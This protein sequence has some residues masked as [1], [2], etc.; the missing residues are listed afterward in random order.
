MIL[1][2][3][4]ASQVLTLVAS[5]LRYWPFGFVR[6]NF[7]MIPLLIFLAGVG[8]VT[9]WQIALRSLRTTSADGGRQPLHVLV[10]AGLCL[11]V[12]LALVLGALAEIGSY[13]QTRD[14]VSPAT[15]YGAEI[16]QAVATVR[17]EAQPGAAVVVTGG[18]MT[19]PG[20]RYYEYEYTGK[21][22]DVGRQIPES[23]VVFPSAHGTRAITEFVDRLRPQEIFLYYP[24]GTT[25]L[26]LQRD[27]RAMTAGRSC[28]QTA[29]RP[30]SS[31]GV[32]ATFHCSRR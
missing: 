16:G 18:V 12:A 7:Y 8:A 30:F 5:Y 22:G 26:Q 23:R 31:S 15:E 28:D 10:G 3:L 25:G 24:D 4:V 32:L 9:A 19:E 27:L 14:S 17:S 21:A 29:V 20:W 2:A 13:R 11:L 6:T 1:F